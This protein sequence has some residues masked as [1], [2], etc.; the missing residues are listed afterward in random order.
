[1]QQY[2]HYFVFY[3]LFVNDSFLKHLDSVTA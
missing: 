3:Q 2:Q 1:M